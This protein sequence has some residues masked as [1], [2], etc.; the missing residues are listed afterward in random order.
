ME[1]IIPQLPVIDYG[2]R[3]WY[4][5]GIGFPCNADQYISSPTMAV[6][7][8]SGMMEQIMERQESR[9]TRLMGLCIRCSTR[10]YTYSC[11]KL[12]TENFQ[13]A[14]RRIQRIQILP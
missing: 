1:R 13:T 14:E 10:I 9:R 4:T 2:V 11:R 12:A 6:S 7:A 3:L 5:N 8:V